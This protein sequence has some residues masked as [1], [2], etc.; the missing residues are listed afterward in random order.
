MVLETDQDERK[1]RIKEFPQKVFKNRFKR[2]EGYFVSWDL[3]F[4]LN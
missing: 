2:G 4:F 3:F 1:D